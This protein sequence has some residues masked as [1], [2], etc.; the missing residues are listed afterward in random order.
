[1]FGFKPNGGVKIQNSRYGRFA[2]HKF[3]VHNTFYMFIKE[4]SCLDSAHVIEIAQCLSVSI[5][6]SIP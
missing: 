4:F 3:Y 6:A 5:E 1:M 2:G